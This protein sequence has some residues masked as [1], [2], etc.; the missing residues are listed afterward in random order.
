MPSVNQDG[1]IST[2]GEHEDSVYVVEWSAAD[3]WLYASLSYDGRL[4]I[5][6]VPKA[7]KYKILL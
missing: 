6:R 5:N 1:V 2:C 4:I 7:V 3:P